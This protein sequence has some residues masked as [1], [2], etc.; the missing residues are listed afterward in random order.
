MNGM[1]KQEQIKLKNKSKTVLWNRHMNNKH[2][3]AYSK[4]E[5]EKMNT[6]K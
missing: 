4:K 5:R 2:K 1:G 6:Q 3:L